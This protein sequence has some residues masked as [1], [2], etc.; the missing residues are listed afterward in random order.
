MGSAFIIGRCPLFLTMLAA[1]V[2]VL[3]LAGCKGKSD[4]Y[5]PVTGKVTYRGFPLQ[6]GTIVF[7]PNTALGTQGELAIGEIGR[8]GT[9]SLRTGN[10][11]GAAAGHY[12]VTVA[13]VSADGAS[14]PGQ[15]FRTPV[16]LLPEKYSDPELSGLECQVMDDKANSFGFELR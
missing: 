1:V 16:S 5:M 9:F 15:A 4:K 13:A 10:A 6:Q 7:T 12:R 2:L 14:I 8:D 11:Y 3:G